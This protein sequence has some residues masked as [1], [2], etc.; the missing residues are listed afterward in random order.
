[1]RFAATTIHNGTRQVQP[2]K[3]VFPMA[4]HDPSP[5]IQPFDARSQNSTSGR[6]LYPAKILGRKRSSPDSGFAE[7]SPK[8]AQPDLRADLRSNREVRETENKL[9]FGG[10][11]SP[12]H[13]VKRSTKLRSVGLKL[14]RVVEPLG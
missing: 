5:G 6:E 7:K 12:H 1:M 9:A 11:R 2:D 3:F 13:A 4:C 14:R 8:F 10:P